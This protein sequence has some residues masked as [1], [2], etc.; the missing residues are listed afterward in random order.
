[1][2]VLCTHKTV[3]QS[4]IAVD[5]KIGEKATEVKNLTKQLDD[6]KAKLDDTLGELASANAVVRATKEKIESQQAKNGELQNKLQD[7]TEKQRKATSD[8]DELSAQNARMRDELD[9]LRTLA[10][11]S[12]VK[13]RDESDALRGEIEQLRSAKQRLEDDLGSV[14]ASM[15]A[16]LAK[17]AALEKDLRAASDA[18]R[19][20]RSNAA[21]DHLTP[22]KK[23]STSSTSTPSTPQQS[24]RSTA[25]ETPST[26]IATSS[27]STSTSASTSTAAASSSSSS[28]EP[29]LIGKLL[30]P[31][32][33]PTVRVVPGYMTELSRYQIGAKRGAKSTTIVYRALD[34]ESK[35]DV[36]LK[37]L[38]DV[39]FVR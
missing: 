25:A 7:L 36:A 6:A 2:W 28:S 32:F 10:N 35:S 1:M 31:F 3:L 16:E 21:I 23:P 14:Q 11:E 39:I 34:K 12:A 24:S 26:P 20:M 19:A 27:T 38:I 17:R 29:G 9:A 13:Q 8:C 22:Q 5:R 30:A 4:F 15:Q 33:S 37:T 18:L